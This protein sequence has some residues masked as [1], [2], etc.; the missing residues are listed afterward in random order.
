MLLEA[1]QAQNSQWPFTAG[2]K[3]NWGGVG[4]GIHN[5]FPHWV[6]ES[7]GLAPTRENVSIQLSM[8]RSAGP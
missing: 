7:L 8:D 2:L 1:Y 5:V 3:G 6:S 4:A